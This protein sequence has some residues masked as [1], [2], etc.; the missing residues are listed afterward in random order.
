MV[1]VIGRASSN[2]ADAGPKRPYPSVM[3]SLIS[4]LAEFILRVQGA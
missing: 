1:P 2:A 4:G 3:V